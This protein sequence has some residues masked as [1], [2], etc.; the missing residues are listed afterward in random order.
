MLKTFRR[1]F[2]QRTPVE[3]EISRREDPADHGQSDQFD[4]GMQ[5]AQ[6]EAEASKGP[7]LLE[8]VAG[9]RT[10]LERQLNAHE[11]LATSLEQIEPL[12]KQ[13]TQRLDVIGGTERHVAELVDAFQASAEKRADALQGAMETMNATAERQVQVLGVL[14]EQID[15]SQGSIQE[16]TQRFEAVGSGIDSLLGAQ[17]ETA[18]QTGALVE[19][20]RDQVTAISLQQRRIFGITIAVL[21]LATIA[22][23]VAIILAA[24]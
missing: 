10:D 22:L 21:S 12:G 5:L 16:L 3:L 24:V 7:E 2:T 19:A 8:A 18:E 15:R 20:V 23:I 13:L 4:A 11:D 9:V 6:D 14:Q 1:I 17:R